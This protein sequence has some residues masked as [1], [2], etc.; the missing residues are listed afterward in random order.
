MTPAYIATVVRALLME[1]GTRDTLVGV[2]ALSFS[3]EIVL[4]SPSGVE[5]HL[6]VPNGP[7]QGIIDLIRRTIDSSE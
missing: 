7:Q 2:A 3:W 4:R 5:Q 1:N 6:I